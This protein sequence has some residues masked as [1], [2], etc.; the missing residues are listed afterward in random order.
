MIGLD[1]R[2]FRQ[3]WGLKKSTRF[4]S[5]LRATWPRL[6]A[7]T[8]LLRDQQH[9]IKNETTKFINASDTS[10]QYK[11]AELKKGEE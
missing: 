6:G 7:K 3:F 11:F 8:A 9:H 5:P 10:S 1:E 4:N 2:N